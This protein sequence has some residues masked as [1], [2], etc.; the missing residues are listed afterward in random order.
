LYE[1]FLPLSALPKYAKDS[2]QPEAHGKLREQAFK[3]TLECLGQT[4]QQL[5]PR[6]GRVRLAMPRYIGCSEQ[7]RTR[8]G[9]K[10]WAQHLELI[11]ELYSGRILAEYSSG[12][13]TL[14]G[15]P[16]TPSTH[17]SLESPCNNG[18]NG[19]FTSEHDL[20]QGELSII[21]SKMGYKGEKKLETKVLRSSA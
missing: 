8:R 16:Y 7:G 2:T 18:I 11:K 6:T 14:H 17:T 15:D 1:G 19:Y 10:Q 3:A 21:T 12:S 13:I 5:R 4:I 9:R 20:L